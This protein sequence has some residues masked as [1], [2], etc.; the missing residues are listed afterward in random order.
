[1]Q[2]VTK[3]LEPKAVLSFFEEISAIPR[4]SKNEKGI[5]DYLVK[6]A[7]DRGLFCV[8]D[9]VHNVFIRKQASAGAEHKP[10]LLMQ[11]HTDIVCEKNADVAHD[12][13]TDPIQMYMDGDWLKA[14]GTTLGADNGTAVAFMLAALDDD[15]LPHPTL[16][17]LFTV[18]E[19]LGLDGAKVFD[20][21]VVTARKLINLDCGPEGETTLC[22]AGGMV[23]RLKKEMSEIPFKGTAL[24]VSVTGL[25]GGHSGGE[26]HRYLGNANKIMARLLNAV[27]GVSLMDI[28]GGS[29]DNAIP[30]ECFAH[31]SVPLEEE[32]R[33]AIADMAVKIKGELGERDENFKVTAEKAAAPEK[34][35]CPNCTKALLSMM[36][37]APNGVIQMSHNFENTVEA[38]SNMGVMKTAGNVVTVTFSPRSAIESINDETEDRLYKLG[39]AFGFS[40]E[41]T[42][43]Y[44]GWTFDKE[45]PL[46]DL[47]VKTYKEL[48]GKDAIMK[49]THGGL[50]LGIFKSKLKDLD[51]IAIGPLAKGAHSPDEKLNI[52]SLNR[53]WE[54][55]KVMMAKMA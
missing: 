37:V 19:E 23:V 10:G 50:E 54:L 11:G 13:L 51:I 45:S 25:A 14:K 31:I 27:K 1:M 26:I 6:F 17:C 16:E 46:R 47:Y 42:A 40:C 30:R 35:F 15:A 29:K 21:S 34:M 48:T 39:E 49:S 2:N 55:L 53:T 38:S 9:E 41:T 12:F 3:G 32:A 20:A 52:P 5:A 24:K 43:R 7:K 18:Q 33:T 44:P 8:R 22:C 4:G 28:D 36:C